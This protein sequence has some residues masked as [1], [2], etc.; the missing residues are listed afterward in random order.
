MR[1]CIA[2]I[3]EE[4]KETRNSQAKLWKFVMSFTTPF[5]KAQK[6]KKSENGK[7]LLQYHCSEKNTWFILVSALKQVNGP[8]CNDYCSQDLGTDLWQHFLKQSG[9]ILFTYSFVHT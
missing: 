2:K 5:N 7:L 3:E 8:L 9:I 6:S 4:V 1:Q